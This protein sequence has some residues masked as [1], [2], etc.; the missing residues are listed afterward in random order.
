MASTTSTASAPVQKDHLRRAD[1]RV[2]LREEAEGRQA[3][4]D[5]LSPREQLAALD[6]RPGRARKERIR[7]LRRI[8]KAEKGLNKKLQK[9]LDELLAA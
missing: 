6:R 2:C 8:A 4:R 5:K 1:L 3:Q 7:L 9:Q